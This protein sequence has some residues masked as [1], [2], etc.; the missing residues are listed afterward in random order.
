MLQKTVPQKRKIKLRKPEEVVNIDGKKIKWGDFNKKFYED[1]ERKLKNGEE[2]QRHE[3]LMNLNDPLKEKRLIWTSRLGFLSEN[4]E[5]DEVKY[6]RQ[7]RQF[8][9]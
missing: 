9:R 7:E 3:F 1:I 4:S 6:K 5:D 2:V 8:L